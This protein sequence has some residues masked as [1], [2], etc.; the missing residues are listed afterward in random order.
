MVLKTVSA[1]ADLME[2]KRMT[3]QDVVSRVAT[4]G[5]I[6]EVG[7]KVIYEMFPDAAEKMFEKTL[8]KR[9]LT[10]EKAQESF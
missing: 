8:E 9:R 3:F 5:G 6:T 4:K 2:Q 1:T 7:S 10:V